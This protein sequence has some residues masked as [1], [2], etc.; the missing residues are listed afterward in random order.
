M[1]HSTKRLIKF[2]KKICFSIGAIDAKTLILHAE[3]DREIPISHSHE[4]YEL[5]K[6]IRPRDWP[7]CKLVE[8]DKNLGLGHSG[9][10]AHAP[11]YSTI[12]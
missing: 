5:C 2:C 11:I 8:L 10:Y 4:L 3:D 12:K 6:K 9:I 1:F 7:T